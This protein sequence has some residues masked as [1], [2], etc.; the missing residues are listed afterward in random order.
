MENRMK[1]ILPVLLIAVSTLAANAARAEEDPI[2]SSFFSPESVMNHQADIGLKDQQRQTI[3]DE[4]KKT[5]AGMVDTQFKMK[6]A[7][8]E[9][10]GIVGSSRVDEAKA[11]SA[12]QKLTKIEHEAK[13][14]HFTL[15]IRIK[16][17]L[18]QEQQ[19]KLRSLPR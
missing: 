8:Q 1:A 6:A 13:T 7:M 14:A 11:I 9:L 10:A 4:I 2:G 17:A 16:N 19:D 12:L 5:Q 15:M 3:I 18:T